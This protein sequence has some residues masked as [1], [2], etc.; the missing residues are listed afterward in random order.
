MIL[1]DFNTGGERLPPT[2][3]PNHKRVEAATYENDTAKILECGDL[4][5]SRQRRRQPPLGRRHS[6]VRPFRPMLRLSPLV[7]STRMR[8][9]LGPDALILDVGKCQDLSPRGSR[10]LI[11]NKESGPRMHNCY[12]L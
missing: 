6:P 7:G 8:A 11:I 4:A 10:Y 2:E 9:S 1:L 3:G 12:G 5:P